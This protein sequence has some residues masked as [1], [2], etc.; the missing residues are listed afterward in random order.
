MSEPTEVTAEVVENIEQRC[1]PWANFIVLYKRKIGHT[2]SICPSPP[3]EPGTYA[4]A[5]RA[6]GYDTR[7]VRV[8]DKP[9]ADE[10]AELLEWMNSRSPMWNDS[11]RNLADRVIA[12]KIAELMEKRDG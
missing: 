4:K 11:E 5:R 10:L 6:E 12:V 9:K 2:F 1:S 3:T 7:I 8:H